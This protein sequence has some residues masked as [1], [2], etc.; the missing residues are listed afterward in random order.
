[1]IHCK[2]KQMDSV[3]EYV[4]YLLGCSRQNPA[5][6]VKITATPS[7]GKSLDQKLLE[8]YVEECGKQPDDKS[9]NYASHL[10]GKLLKRER[11]NCLVLS[12]YPGTEGY[13]LMLRARSGVESETIKLPYEE[14]E[15]LE[16]I[17]AA[18]LPPFLLDLLEKAQVNVFYSGC[19]I[20]EV[21]DYRRSASGCYDAHYVLLRPSAQSLLCD[22]LSLAAEYGNSSWTQDDFQQLESE[23]LLA[24]SEPLC[25]DPSPAV[26]MVATELTRQQKMF[27]DPSLKRSIKRYTQVAQN[28]KKKLAQG[29]AP[30]ELRLLDFLHK[31]RDKSK[32]G[33]AANKSIKCSIDTWKQRSVQLN[34]PEN[35]EVEKFFKVPDRPASP[36]ENLILVEEHKLERDPNQEHRM[37][38]CITI[39]R[40]RLADGFIGRLY[41]DHDYSGEES[42]QKGCSCQFPL[43]TRQNVDRYLEQFKELF[44]EEGRRLVKI[45][46]QRAGQAPEVV[47]TQVSQTPTAA[48]SITITSSQALLKQATPVGQGDSTNNSLATKRNIPIQLSLSITPVGTVSTTASITSQGTVV[49]S[50]GMTGQATQLQASS[51]RFKQLN[52]HSRA[53]SSPLASPASTPTSAPQQI[54]AA[55]VSQQSVLQK[56]PTPTPAPTPP[57]ISRTPTPTQPPTPTSSTSRRGS[58]QAGDGQLSQ[59][60]TAQP[61][62]QQTSNISFVQQESL[63]GVSLSQPST[64]GTQLSNI[65][66]ASISSLPPN[67]NLQGLTGLQGVS[68]GLQHMQVSLSMPGIAVPVPITMINTNPS[69]LQNQTSILLPGGQQSIPLLSLQQQQQQRGGQ[70]KTGTLT[71]TIATTTAGGASRQ[72]STTTTTVPLS[73]VLTSQQMSALTSL[74]VGKGGGTTAT[75]LSAHQ[76]IHLTGGTQGTSSTVST[77]QGGSQTIHTQIALQKPAGSSGQTFQFH[78]LHLKQGAVAT[79]ALAGTGIS[80]T[81]P[82]IKKRGGTTPPKS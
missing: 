68:L 17:D 2:T 25:L 4:E 73:G 47:L 67:I 27:N 26:A 31:K 76:F 11:L 7:K 72:G 82:K 74:T 32:I 28:R 77:A 42:S 22:T 23:M 34:T 45:T 78:P 39:Y 59:Q 75:P 29:P 81:K 57:P 62:Q 33:H 66:I 79:S 70:L 15:V 58:L 56:A 35:L 41:L 71:A 12:L 53:N 65:N 43:G 5:N 24:T 8:L 19:V 64:Q 18:E 48:T 44:T 36:G 46:T 10:L 6:L 38:A 51:Q 49:T 61:G 3:A 55:L 69:I 50:A 14:T 13:S 9:L 63:G 52:L 80:T 37:L 16:Y 20:V 60:A 40:Q 30:R 54:A 1:M 21:R